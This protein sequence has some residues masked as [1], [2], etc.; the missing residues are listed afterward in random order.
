MQLPAVP[1]FIVC[2]QFNLFCRLH[3]VIPRAQYSVFEYP[4]K[5]LNVIVVKVL[6]PISQWVAVLSLDMSHY[7]CIK[8][9]TTSSFRQLCWCSGVECPE[10]VKREGSLASRWN[11]ATNSDDGKV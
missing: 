8:R 11:A 5:L 2:L 9:R 1:H 6:A 4:V 3:A 7:Y 10:E